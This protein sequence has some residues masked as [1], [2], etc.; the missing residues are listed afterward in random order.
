MRLS[1]KRPL[2]ELEETLETLLKTFQIEHEWISELKVIRRLGISSATI[3]SPAECVQRSATFIASCTEGGTKG[4]PALEVSWSS[5]YA[6][7]IFSRRSLSGAN[8]SVCRSGLEERC[9]PCLTGK[10]RLSKPPSPGCE[11]FPPPNFLVGVGAGAVCQ[12]Q[13]INVEAL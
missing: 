1:W 3:P 2:I 10:K 4:L 5:A 8:R 12:F 9:K 13:R 7:K 11:H 6:C